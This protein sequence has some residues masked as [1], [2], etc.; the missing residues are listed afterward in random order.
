VTGAE[1]ERWDVEGAFSV[2]LVGHCKVH[3]EKVERPLESYMQ[4]SDAA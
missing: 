4:K 2:V 1:S 3:L